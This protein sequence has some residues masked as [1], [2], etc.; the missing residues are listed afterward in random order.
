MVCDPV[1]TRCW[2]SN[3]KGIDALFETIAMEAWYRIYFGGTWSSAR[4]EWKAY[5]RADFPAWWALYGDL[6]FK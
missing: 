6:S 4:R 5:P 3:M 1:W 2:E